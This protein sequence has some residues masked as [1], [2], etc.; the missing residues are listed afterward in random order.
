MKKRVVIVGLGDTGLLV[1]MGLN[2]EFEVIGITPKPALV[3]GQELGLRVSRPDDWRRHYRIPF[4]RYRGLRGVS[5]R[6]GLVIGL[7]LNERTVRLQTA[8]G[9]DET[10]EWDALVL[11][12]G[13]TNGFWR[14]ATVETAEQ[15]ERSIDEIASRLASARSIAVIGG[16]ASAVSAASNL[17]EAYPATHITLAFSQSSLLTEYHPRVREAVKARLAAQG[18]EV[19][20]QHRAEVPP[21]GSPLTSGP[22]RFVTG[23]P[24]LEPDVALWAIGRVRPNTSFL[25]PELL[26]T[27]GF[28]RVD[29]HLRV[30]TSSTV[31]AVGDAAAT[32]PQRCSARNGGAKLV[33]RNVRAVLRGRP[34]R[35]STF[36]PPSHRWGSIFG[37]QRDG[38]R[39]FAPA[40]FSVRIAPFLVRQILFPW[41]VERVIY[42]GIEPVPS[43]ARSE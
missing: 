1:A 24:T 23:Q 27:N 43:T 13:V 25:P 21:D 10:L 17:K 30:P 26:D 7:G 41:I 4:E 29:G 38:L 32:D 20:P 3:S 12:P 22:V 15:V 35:L 31:F 16:G 8:T 11:A 19:R 28:I 18:I 40:G 42:G 2:P 33:A 9:D 36:R 14:T 6:H 5:V 37:P 39:V 34:E